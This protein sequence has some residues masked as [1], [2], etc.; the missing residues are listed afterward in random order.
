[1]LRVQLGDD[2]DAE[3]LAAVAR[4]ERVKLN[5]G[6]EAQQR[7]KRARAT[8]DAIVKRG[9][10]VY[11]VNTGFGALAKEQ[12]SPEDTG[13]LQSNLLLSHA[14]GVGPDMSA[15]E[16]RLSL[17]LRI[18]SLCRGVSGVRPQMVRWFIDLFHSG[19]LP[20]VPEQGSVGACGDLAPLAHQALPVIGAGK[21]VSPQG[22]V[23]ST[24]AA[25]KKIGMEPMELAAKE[26]IGLINGVQV[27]NAIGLVAWARLC[28]L[29]V[30]ADIAGSLS[31][32]AL[33][34]SHSPFDKRVTDVRP[35]PGAQRTSANL[36][37]LLKSSGVR[38]AHAGCSR[39]QDPYSFRCMPQVHG[40]AK[41]ALTFVGEALV[42]EANSATDNPLVF[43]ER[44]DSISAG[45]F[46]GQPIALA[47]D[48]AANALC[49]WGNISE[50]RVST[51]IHPSMSELP[52]FLTPKPGLS[53][54]LMIPQVVAA[55]LVSENKTH[56][57]PASADTVTT[58]ADQEDH[59]SMANF[60]ARKLR[61]ATINTERVLGIEL[62]TAAQGREF[63]K[64]LKA[65][66][67]AQAAYDFIRQHIK[68]LKH[69][70]FMADELDLMT[71][72]V[73]S[74]AIRKAVEKACGKL[75]V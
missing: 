12:I 19:W 58:S 52:A 56:A 33:M 22:K 15:L 43:P 20:H 8:V 55:A 1:M 37:Q 38:K 35:H 68:P 29:S 54:G 36:R 26:G 28:D 53:S 75:R 10:P 47:M 11:G 31:V 18:H 9:A 69:D 51:L 14:V 25:L 72:L 17:M 44:G 73:G 16:K 61:Q 6:R 42:R 5:F 64:E 34:G 66:V 74:G 39:V 23:M 27:S 21:L 30:T 48:F 46:H 2:L 45:N 65:G 24:R 57:H 4:G 32:E 62:Y 41:D 49:S 70:R 13:T 3:T 63:H 59:V 50:R 7:V 67:G 60:A 40:A 71:E